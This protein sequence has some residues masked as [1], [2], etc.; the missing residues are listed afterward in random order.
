MT[1]QEPAFSF[2]MT[3]ELREL[4]DT[5]VEGDISLPS[6]VYSIRIGCSRMGSS[7]N[8][9]LNQ[10]MT[11]GA[12][13]LRDHLK[14]TGGHELPKSRCNVPVTAT[15]MAWFMANPDKDNILIT[16]VSSFIPGPTRDWLESCERQ[17]DEGVLWSRADISEC[18]AQVIRRERFVHSIIDYIEN[19]GG[20]QEAR[21]IDKMQAE[22]KSCE[23]E[24][25]GG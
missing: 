8:D 1:K 22:I 2:R 21:R 19:M 11:V 20:A 3:S 12:Y 10:L 24:R 25:G 17:D 18:Y 23:E 13:A 15:L 7:I 14:Q 5:I 9:V 6:G 4:V 16:D